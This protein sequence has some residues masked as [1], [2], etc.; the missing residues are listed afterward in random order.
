MKV[1]VYG[2][3]KYGCSNHSNYLSKSKFIGEYETEPIYKFYSINDFYPAIK[4]GGYSSILMEVYEVTD[5]QLKKIDGLEGYN[6]NTPKTS[7]YDRVEINTP[8]GKAYTYLYNNGIHGKEI[9]DTNDWREYKK[10]VNLI[11]A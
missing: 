2:T 1:A 11:Q 5:E 9:T 3:L 10:F 7:L 4:E 6:K 8:Y